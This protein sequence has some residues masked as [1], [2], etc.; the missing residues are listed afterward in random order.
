[1][2]V[3][4]LLALATDHWAFRTTF[5][6]YSKMKMTLFYAVFA[7]A[8]AYCFGQTTMA[9]NAMPKQAVCNM[10]ADPLRTSQNI[11]GVVYFWQFPDS[12]ISIFVNVSGLQRFPITAL[13]SRMHGLHVHEYGDLS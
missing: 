7:A 1:M 12:Q 8:A 5:T 6:S 10:Q 11:T 2:G 3:Q 9:P 4:S 13:H